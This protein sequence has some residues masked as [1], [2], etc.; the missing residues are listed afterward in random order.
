MA[1]VKVNTYKNHR[2]YGEYGQDLRLLACLERILRTRL[3][4]EQGEQCHDLS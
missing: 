3:S 4:L 1:A 2:H